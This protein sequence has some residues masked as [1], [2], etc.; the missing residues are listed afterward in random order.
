MWDFASCARRTSLPAALVLAALIAAGAPASIAGAAAVKPKK[1]T[2]VGKTKTEDI[3][4]SA[5][6]IGFTVRGSKILLT[7]EPVVRRHD[8]LS[9]PGFLLV[10][11][12]VSTKI[13]PSGRFTFIR[14]VF[15]TKVDKVE[16]RFTSRDRIEGKVTDHFPAQYLCKE[17]KKTVEFTATPGTTT[18]TGS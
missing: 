16:G 13:H 11:D 12:S 9:P 1:G 15:G 17:G 4:D 18:T 5:R 14:T 2:Y 7:E 3:I 6:A 8:C 10:Q